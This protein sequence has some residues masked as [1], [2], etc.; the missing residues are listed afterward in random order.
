MATNSEKFESIIEQLRELFA[1]EGAAQFARGERTAIDRIV[2]AA[3]HEPKRSN[4]TKEPRIR[5]RRRTKINYPKKRA[6]SGAAPALVGRVLGEAGPKG[7]TAQEIQE[8]AKTPV[9]KLVS[10]SGIRFA[11]VQ[12]RSAGRY[13]NK[14]GRWFV[15]HRSTEQAA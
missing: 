12:G 5:L 13:R 4:D 7:A 3:Q 2:H 15:A 10:Y 1:A 9:E 8:A 11:L 6:P 14:Q